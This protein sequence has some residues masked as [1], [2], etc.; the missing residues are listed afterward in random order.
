M[1][2]SSKTESKPRPIRLMEFAPF[3]APLMFIFG[4]I[5]VSVPFF[6]LSGLMLYPILKRRFGSDAWRLTFSLLCRSLLSVGAAL[7]WLFVLNEL[8]YSIFFLWRYHLSEVV[9]FATS[10]LI[11]YCF[12]LIFAKRFERD[13]L[14]VSL[15]SFGLILSSPF[16]LIVEPWRKRSI[17]IFIILWGLAL[18]I[19]WII[20]YRRARRKR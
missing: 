5:F 4:F 7:L 1:F 18:L 19:C 12:Q 3:P 20:V 13:V 17:G 6:V 16:Y 9:F 10:M 15:G 14:L 8:K 2:L 11:F